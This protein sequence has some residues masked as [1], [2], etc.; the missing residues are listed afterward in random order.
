MLAEF[1]EQLADEDADAL[2]IVFASSDSDQHSFDEY[3]G[4]MP[5]VAIP[6]TASGK[7]QGLGSKFGVRGIPSL[8][9]LDAA[10]GSIKDG[11]G[12][13]TVSNARGVTSKATAKWA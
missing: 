10:D 4:S 9:I 12:R 6:F 3:Y 8:I 11:D 1:F 7:A 5:W 13:S 2:A